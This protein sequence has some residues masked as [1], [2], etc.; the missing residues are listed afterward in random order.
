LGGA[1]LGKMCD[2]AIGGGAWV[3]SE[4]GAT[5]TPKGKLERVLAE[6]G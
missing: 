1:G 5:P 4:V 3:A 6:V 2:V